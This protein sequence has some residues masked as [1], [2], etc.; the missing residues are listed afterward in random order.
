MVKVTYEFDTDEDANDLKMLQLS[1]KF[2]SSLHVI[3]DMVRN[4]QKHG[5][6]F[7]SPESLLDAI[8]EESNIVWEI[9]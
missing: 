8:K 5:T 1:H 4:Y 7:D 3:Y 9:E 6:G 2:Y